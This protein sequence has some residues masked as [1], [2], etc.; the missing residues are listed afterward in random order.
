MLYDKEFLLKL[1]KQKNK[2][3]YAR[4]TALTFQETPIEYIE[5]RVTQGSINLDGASAVR[6]S[7]SLTIVAQDFNYNDYYWGLNTKFKLEIGVE[8]TV[9]SS[10]PD[11][12]WFKQGI[13]VITSFNTSR[14]TNSFNISIQGKDKMCL[15]NGEVGG[16]LESSVDFGTIE[17][18]DKNGNQVIRKLPIIDIIRNAVHTYGGEP[19]HNI[20]INDIEN[21][22]L[23]LLEYRLKTPLYLY[24]EFGNPIY[25][26]PVLGGTEKFELFSVKDGVI[27]KRKCLDIPINSKETKTEVQLNE[28][29]DEEFDKYFEMLVD[30]FVGA[31]N[32][33]VFA[34]VS[35]KNTTSD[36][37]DTSSD[38][39]ERKY[40]YFTKIKPGQTV[41]YRLTDLVYAG[42]LIA[43]VGESLA[44]VL[45]K[46]KNMLTE[47]EY[48]YN[49]D[50][51]FV[52]QKKQSVKET[53][54]AIGDQKPKQTIVENNHRAYEFYNGD[55]I[56]AFNNN[57][58]LLNLRNDYSIWGEREAVS[59]AKI[60]IHLR[61]AI[62]K[63]P[64]QY[65]TIKVDYGYY[66]LDQDGNIKLD[67]YGKEIFIEGT[68]YPAIK[69]YNDKYNTTLKGQS[70]KTYSTDVYDWRE[71]IYQMAKDYYKYNILEDFE[72]RVA[73]ANPDLYP[74]GRTGYEQYY[75]DIQGF[76]RQ[77]YYPELSDECEE[78]Y[79]KY[80]KLQEETKQL[81]EFLYG[82]VQKGY[83]QR[84]GGL[85]NNLT[86]LSELIEKENLTDDE[87]GTINTII[88][89]YKCYNE[90][91]EQI[92]DLPYCFRYIN[93]LYYITKSKLE[94]LLIDYE[95]IENKFKSLED[96]M[97]N[98]Y[99]IENV[100]SED[101]RYWN[102]FVFEAPDQL[103]FWFDFLDTQGDLQ[104]FN[105]QTIGSRS[106]PINDTAIKSIYF[107]DTPQVLFK[108]TNDTVPITP[109]YRV[110]QR[111]GIK[112]MFTCSAQGKSAKNKLDE[113]IYQ[114]GYCIE[115]ATI[116]TIP[117]YYLEPNTRIYIH[118]DETGLDG[119]Y[120]TSKITIPLTYNGTMSITATKAAETII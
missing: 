120:I 30:G 67:Q 52:F 54:F 47:F 92:T 43:N 41:G 88:D 4:I 7:C 35:D 105:V 73:E 119:D 118:D 91:N 31:G 13:Y 56:T 85:E 22:G 40:Y 11:I 28:L 33:P 84:H 10:Y 66:D 24:R 104:Q 74:T 57:P 102:K 34:Q 38:E 17:E 101:R 112:D 6:R 75:I 61:Y 113:L 62:D 2:T 25:T 14:N 53:F 108:D 45:D 48:F 114:H 68:D 115:S 103:N 12:I 116:T 95:E 76:W 70:S 29:N 69:A 63:K 44:S 23:E 87:K 109:G 16:S 55:L 81:D 20:I 82:V 65:K 64:I 18:E 96:K 97:K 77:L 93:N 90:K 5:G 72:L 39:P 46:I 60:P 94:T 106:K 110:I 32:P 15:L 117:I 21:F 83:T 107:R 71:I 78:T 58:N 111:G 37:E 100:P 86:K 89:T 27:D 42:D 3:I 98:D 9:D 1:D 79:Q 26:N 59:G 36:D 99:Y 49:L 8:N 50:G 51:Q 19:Y 80:L